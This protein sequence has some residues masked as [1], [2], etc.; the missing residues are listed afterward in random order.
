MSRNS[1][2]KAD[3]TKPRAAKTAAGSRTKTARP[4]THQPKVDRRVLRTGDALG[5]ALVD[6]MHEKSF[7]DI[8]VQQVLDRAGVGR[9]TFYVHYRDKHDLFVSDVEEF[10][11]MFSTV[12]RRNG[13]SAKR[14]APVEE[15]FAH[16]REAREFYA[17]LVA[18][19]KVN[20]VRAL[21]QGLFARSIEERLKM[22]G[23]ETDATRRAAHAHALAGSLFALLDWWIDKGMKADP[24][25]MD[26]VFHRMAWSGLTVR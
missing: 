6:L 23:V 19:G 12:L 10:F 15:L 14:L 2:V 21:G 13:E 26:E 16:V 3:R 7:D 11:E 5:D 1:V 18:A 4:Q 24:G 8:T 9:S 25:E 22:A 20:D 17:A